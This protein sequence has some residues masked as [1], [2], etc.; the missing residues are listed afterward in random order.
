MRG[1]GVSDVEGRRVAED[2]E[3]APLTPT[4]RVS[5]H[6]TRDGLV[7]GVQLTSST[8][9]PALIPPSVGRLKSL[10]L[11][12]PGPQGSRINQR[13]LVIEYTEGVRGTKERTGGVGWWN[14]DSISNFGRS[15][16]LF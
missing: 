11:L 8:P 13:S 9:A 10:G 6:T 16:Y 3:A 4:D 14:L 15:F 12:E 5:T 2:V 1:P 7:G